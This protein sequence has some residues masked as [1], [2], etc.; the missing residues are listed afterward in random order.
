[1]IDINDKIMTI[2]YLSEGR[3]PSL[4]SQLDEK[5]DD[6]II[7]KINRVYD[8]IKKVLEKDLISNFKIMIG[9]VVAF[10]NL[11]NIYTFINHPIHLNV[12]KNK[13][14]NTYLQARTTIKENNKVKWISAYVGPAN[15]YIKGVEDPFAL[16]KGTTLIRKK[17]IKHYRI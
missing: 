13:S 7:E 8:S 4:F 12:F 3:T 2:I 5:E 14:G 17:L 11:D 16:R 1:M 10:D 9:A 15:E 6:Y